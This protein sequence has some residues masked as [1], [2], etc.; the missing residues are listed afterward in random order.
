MVMIAMKREQLIPQIV[1]KT[2]PFQL[3]EGKKKARTN[4]AKSGP[5]IDP[6][7]AMEA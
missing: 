2:P 3:H 7:I 5:R 6:L 4:S 1:P